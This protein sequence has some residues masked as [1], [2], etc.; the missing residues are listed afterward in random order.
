RPAS[1][2]KDFGMRRA[3][4]LP[5]FCTRVFIG[6]PRIYDEDTRSEEPGS[7]SCALCPQPPVRLAAGA[8]LQGDVQLL[9]P[10]ADLVA[11][12]EVL[13]LAGLVAQVD[14]YLNQPLDYV[15]E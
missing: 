10:R 15:V 1:A 5:H 2:A 8:V 9:Q 12:R 7:R 13:R 4:L 6:P 3:R 11:Q 14:Q